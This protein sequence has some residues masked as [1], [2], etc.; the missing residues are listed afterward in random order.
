MTA[1]VGSAGRVVP[2]GASCPTADADVGTAVASDGSEPDVVAGIDVVAAGELG[3][4]WAVSTSAG[5]H[6]AVTAMT[7]STAVR[8]VRPNA[9]R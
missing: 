8:A 3:E 5:E 2:L 1:G 9:S 7:A 4:V 6:A